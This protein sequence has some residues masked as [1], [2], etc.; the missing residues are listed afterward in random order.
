MATPS[1]LESEIGP[2]GHRIGDLRL[3]GVARRRRTKVREPGS[4]YGL[5]HCGAITWAGG[6]IARLNLSAC[7]RRKAG[8][9]DSQPCSRV[10]R[11][12]RAGL[13]PCPPG[14]GGRPPVGLP[15]AARAALR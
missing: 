6:T 5:V 2:T 9:H 10:N 4:T 3:G 7:W 11:V 12:V 15:R 13:F 14:P 1:F 8:N